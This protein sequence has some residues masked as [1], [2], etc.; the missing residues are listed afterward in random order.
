MLFE[1]WRRRL[2]GVSVR[3][4]IMGIGLGMLTLLSLGMVGYIRVVLRDTLEDEL[5]ARGLSL[6]H[7]VAARVSTTLQEPDGIDLHALA[8]EPIS[9]FR[10]I[11]YVLIL[12]AEQNILA[13]AFGAHPAQE[14]IEEHTVPPG[15]NEDVRYVPTEVCRLWD[16]AVKINGGSMGTARVGIDNSHIRA[17]IQRTSNI[18]LLVT[19]GTASIGMAAAY[20]LTAMM[21]RPIRELEQIAKRV[22]TRDFSGKTE[23]QFD[24]EVGRLT[25]AFSEM[26]KKLAESQAAIES[27]NQELV[28]RDESRRELLHQVIVAQEEERYR[29]AREL[30]D[31]TSQVLAAL[32]VTL[33]SLDTVVRRGGMVDERQIQ[34]AQQMAKDVLNE[35][36][37][38]MQNLRPAMLDDLGLAAAIRWWI[39]QCSVQSK[40]QF[41]MRLTDESRLLALRHPTLDHHEAQVHTFRVIQEGVTNI[42]KHASAERAW[43]VVE[44]EE[45]RLHLKISDDGIGFDSESVLSSDQSTGHFGLRGIAERVELLAGTLEISAE[46]G[47]GT[48][49]RIEIP[50]APEEEE[51]ELEG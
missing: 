28:K 34:V 44:F 49:L 13:H 29:I 10:D 15:R 32:S 33:G 47:Q 39:Q 8:L 36:R 3:I 38:V 23:A 27:Y 19:L 17:Q 18:L 2:L 14:L 11:R 16:V 41:S 51:T 21:I 20:L 45:N 24:D 50:L 25:T 9:R 26:I 12:D 31:E 4:K 40:T 42:L 43:V 7:H 5:K 22:G 46:L 30:H 48:C 6:A 1:R 35:V 37:R